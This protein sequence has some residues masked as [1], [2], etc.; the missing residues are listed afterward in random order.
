MDKIDFKKSLK[1]FYQ[2]TNRHFE[3]VEVP[4][5][6]FAMVDGS[7]DPNTAQAYRS[8]V[9]WLYGVSYAIKFAAKASLGKDYVVPPL[10]GLWWS[11]DPADFVAR[12]KDAWKWTMMILVPD[13]AGSALFA[14]AL[15]K[16][17][18]KRGSRGLRREHACRRCISAVMT[19]RGRC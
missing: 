5:M 9:E 11:D 15:D 18:A 19:R 6:Q 8:A 7:G 10:E 12:R 13:F 16:T 1:A 2:P 14:A 3:P 17:A 4:E